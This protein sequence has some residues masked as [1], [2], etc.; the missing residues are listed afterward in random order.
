MEYIALTN[1]SRI[2]KWEKKIER[3]LD[4][5]QKINAIN[6]KCGNICLSPFNNF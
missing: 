5:N 4:K 2:V 6:N 3:M 1:F